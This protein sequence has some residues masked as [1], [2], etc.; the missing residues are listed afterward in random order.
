MAS[1]SPAWYAT[2][3]CA[4]QILILQLLFCHK[5][6]HLQVI[7]LRRHWNIRKQKFSSLV[8]K[9]TSNKIRFLLIIQP[10][11]L[12]LLPINL[13]AAPISMAFYRHLHISLYFFFLTIT[14]LRL[15]HDLFESHLPTA[16]TLTCF[17]LTIS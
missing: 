3:N 2:S 7:Q 13:A 1:I 15:I 14:H 5:I 4:T 9:G 8:K 16:S 11:F 12:A 10:L 17:Y 6:R